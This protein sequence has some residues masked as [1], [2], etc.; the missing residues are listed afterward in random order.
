MS[1]AS[2]AAHAAH[3]PRVEPS[4]AVRGALTLL[5]AY[6]LLLSPFF[7]GACRYTPSCSDYMAAA[8][9]EHGLVTGT[10]LGLRRL[11]RCHPFGGHG[12]DPVPR[13]RG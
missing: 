12:F 13:R 10:W 1:P 2:I 11:A 5:R 4:L 9:R 7:S 3:A 6:K 8:L